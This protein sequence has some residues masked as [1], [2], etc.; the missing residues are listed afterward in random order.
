[1]IWLIMGILV[2]AALLFLTQPLYAKVV[3]ASADDSEAADYA[4]QIADIDR[5]IE[6]GA[7]DEQTLLN[8]KTE[9]SRQL[10]ASQ[11]NENKDDDT[12]PT[13]LLAI[14]FVVF[15]F[16]ALGIYSQVGRPELM[17]QGALQMPRP[18]KAQEAMP[19]IA[20]DQDNQK[21]MEQLVGQLEQKLKEDP[22][23]PDG[24]IL[25]ARSLMHLARYDEA[26]TAYEKVLS[27]TNND[28]DVKVELESARGFVQ[29]QASGAP[30][31]APGPSASDIEAA[32]EMTPQDRMVMIE[33]MVEGL[34]AKLEDNPQ[35][36]DGWIR[37]L[38]ARR[39]LG[40]QDQASIE[41][42]RMKT[43]FAGKPQ[44]IER[45]LMESGWAK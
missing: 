41:I 23:N 6:A 21:S 17:K 24:W 44:T 28:P 8:A 13:L 3:N 12:Q 18:A 20:P 16:G 36:V 34:S 11:D 38:N 22:S 35:D 15:C 4:Q 27:L 42:A 43:V 45:I 9:L 30:M 10:L 25:Y 32:G 39:V 40:Q 33:G 31:R 19:R 14:L 29:R 37:L 26:L 5:Q 2:L 7:S 1:M